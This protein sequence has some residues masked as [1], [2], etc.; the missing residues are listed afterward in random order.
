M[1]VIYGKS[2]RALGE[3]NANAIVRAIVAMAHNL[4]LTVV[5]EGVETDSQLALLRMLGCDV[6]QGYL[7]SRPLPAQAFRERLLRKS[8]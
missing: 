6:Y 4:G 7:C 3:D 2:I 1:T 8:A 5:A